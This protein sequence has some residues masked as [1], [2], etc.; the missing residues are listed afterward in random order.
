MSLVSYP[1]AGG[2]DDEH[3]SGGELFQHG[4]QVGRRYHQVVS[5][6]HGAHTVTGHPVTTLHGHTGDGDG[7]RVSG[8]PTGDVVRRPE[9]PT[10][11]TSA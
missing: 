11:A 9:K 3:G 1:A 10:A 7:V 8:V 5:K 4:P 2:A 6:V